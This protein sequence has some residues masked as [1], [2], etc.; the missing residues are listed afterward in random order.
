MLPGPPLGPQNGPLNDSLA[1]VA[2]VPPDRLGLSHELLVVHAHE[3]R[4]IVQQQLQVLQKQLRAFPEHEHLLRFRFFPLSTCPRS[5]CD[6]RSVAGLH[7]FSVCVL[8]SRF[9]AL[10]QLLV[11]RRKVDV[12]GDVRLH[13]GQVD[14]AADHLQVIGKLVRTDGCQKGFQKLPIDFLDERE[15]VQKP[16]TGGLLQS[17]LPGQADDFGSW[18]CFLNIFRS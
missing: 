5:L 10:R 18:N 17:L 3:G 4:H 11:D 9:P 12:I 15:A 7:G 14:R 8:A 2:S 6:V 16:A 13:Q 1:D